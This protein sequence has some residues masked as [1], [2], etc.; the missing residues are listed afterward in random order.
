MDIYYIDYENVNSFGLKGVHLLGDNSQVN[1]LYSKKADNVKI[2]ALTQLMMSKAE[3]HFIPVHVGTPNALDFQL[4]TLLFLGYQSGNRYFIIS[5]DSGYDC[6]IKTARENGAPDVWRFRDIESAV[7]G[8]E[9][10]EAPSL[11]APEA[12][13]QEEAKNEGAEADSLTAAL[14]KAENHTSPAAGDILVTILPDREADVP[15][16]FQADSQMKVQADAQTSPQPDA[17]TDTLP[18]PQSASGEQNPAEGS[19][20]HRS[21]RRRR[22]SRKTSQAHIAAQTAEE[23]GQA[24]QNFSPEASDMQES[25]PKPEPDAASLKGQDAAPR[26][27]PDSSA[28]QG[29]DAAPRQNQDNSPVRFPSGK[30]SEVISRKCGFTP[31]DKQLMVISDVLRKAK[32]KQQFYS[33]IVRRCGQKEGLALYHT[34]RP[35]YNDLLAI[36]AD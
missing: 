11:P 25:T 14:D 31:D 8:T 13:F 15:A 6:S 23:E 3:I 26:Q 30:V 22:S 36:E 16:N 17:P 5:K 34:I 1:I 19:S 33:S 20:Q 10:H 27:N 9:K 12:A 2:D 7:L 18:E 21:R 35:A 29:Q 28:R 32:N 4:I 24:R